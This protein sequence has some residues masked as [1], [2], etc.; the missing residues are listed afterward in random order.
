MLL[1]VETQFG[2]PICLELRC[3]DRHICTAEARIARIASQEE[4][5]S[6]GLIG[7]VMCTFGVDDELN[8]VVVE[9]RGDVSDA[10]VTNSATGSR[11]VNIHRSGSV[12]VAFVLDRLQAGDTTF[13]ASANK[14]RARCHLAR[15]PAK[16]SRS[17]I[18]P[19]GQ[20]IDE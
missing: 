5:S 19:G 8:V 20:I 2:R 14:E 16:T 15:E 12:G 7:C 9:L 18:R 10:H 11:Q 4:P 17:R 1:E 13:S 3:N 6:S